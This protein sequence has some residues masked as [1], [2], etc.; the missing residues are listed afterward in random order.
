MVVADRDHADIW[1]V[2]DGVPDPEVPAVS[3]V[4]LGI[5]RGVEVG[6]EGRVTVSVTPTYSGCPALRVIEDD[7]VT[8]LGH[9]GWTDVE[10][11]TVLAPAWTTDW[12]GDDAR[13]KMVAYGIAPPPA[14]AVADEALVPL[15]R[16]LPVVACPYCGSE[17]TTMRSEF[18]ATA[19][20]AVMFCS[21]CHQPFELFKAL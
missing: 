17:A 6:S 20:K 5:V 9:H 4:E 1:A 13:R 3:I 2:L 16:R 15:Q 19:C 10:I 7:I 14:R 21:R 8:A 11:R 12:I 18:G